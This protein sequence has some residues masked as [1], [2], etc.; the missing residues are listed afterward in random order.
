MATI[1]YS[2]SSK[3]DKVTQQHEILMRF[4]HGRINQRAKTRIYI[5]ASD[6]QPAVVG[7]DKRKV[8]TRAHIIGAKHPTM[9]RMRTD[10]KMQQYNVQL[11]LYSQLETKQLQLNAIE[12]AVMQSFQD[13][14]DTSSIA[15]NSKWLQNVIDQYY[16]PKTSIDENNLEIPFFERFESFIKEA[17]VS[18]NRRAHY[19]VVCRCLKRFEIYRKQPIT[20]DSITQDFIRDFESFLTN[21]HIICEQPE[22]KYLYESDSD[23]DGNNQQGRKLRKPLPRGKNTIIDILKKLRAFIIWANNNHYSTTN[24]FGRD[25][26]IIGECIYGT[27]YYLT[28]DERNCLY[29][30]DFS[31][32][33]RL[34]IS[35]D[36]FVFQC[37]IGCR[38]SDLWAMTTSN[39][40]G[41]FIEYVAQKT[42]D[43]RADTIVVPLNKISSAILKKYE[44]RKNTRLFPFPT[45]QQ[46]NIDIKTM[47]REAG[48]RRM[49]TIINPTTREEE[50]KPICDIASSHIAR[51]TFIGN[52]YKAVQDPNIVGSMTGHIEGSKA[53]ARYRTIDDDIKKSVLSKIE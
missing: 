15:G 26:Y 38:V 24:P 18:N 25:R 28:I 45:Q 32:D 50:K 37:L 19:N 51:R 34:E 6:W 31:Y 36:I 9:P 14:H 40:I 33:R 39:I 35:R 20:F 3:C 46:Y 22:Y 11:E 52:A 16:K 29:K 17:E 42:K 53:F 47:L 48:I 12:K 8:A 21:E 4:F 7:D 30:F 44:K 10:E 43:Q 49:V 41:D 23:T 2:L 13:L 27:P 1:E 5:G